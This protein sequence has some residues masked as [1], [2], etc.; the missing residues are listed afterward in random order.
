MT[1]ADFFWARIGVVVFTLLYLLLGKIDI[2]TAASR[3]AS[4]FL[5]CAGIL[6]ETINSWLNTLSWWDFLIYG[7]LFAVSVIGT[8][9]EIMA[10]GGV[11]FAYKIV[12]LLGKV[13]LYGSSLFVIGLALRHDW[14]DSN[15]WVG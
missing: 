9:L 14:E 11:A 6:I 10:S 4:G 7:T 8:I 3:I 5:E 15:S 12:E 1:A 2:W 13:F